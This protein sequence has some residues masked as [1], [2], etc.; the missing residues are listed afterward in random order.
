MADEEKKSQV[1]R[2]YW[3]KMPE[4]FFASKRIKRLRMMAGGDTYTII[5]LKLQLKALKEDGY[6]YFDNVMGDFVEELALDIDEKPDDVKVTVN[7]LLSVGLMESS[8]D[9]DSLS[10]PYL[11]ELIGSESVSAQRMRKLRE[12]RKGAIR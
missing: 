8:D 11:R 5:Y 12:T 9:G 7:Y 3:L 10:L 1:K 6:L 4:D 2:Y